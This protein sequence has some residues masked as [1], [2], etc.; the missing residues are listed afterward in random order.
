MK[1]GVADHAHAI[2][3]LILRYAERI[4]AGDLD[5]LAALFDQ[6]VLRTEGFP[7]L[8]RGRDEVRALYAQMVRL[9]DGRPSTQHITTNIRVE[10]SPDEGTAE[11][12]SKYTVFQARPELPLQAIISGRYHDTFSRDDQGWHFTERV[13][14]IDLVGDLSQHLKLAL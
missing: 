8:R 7:D 6:A 12:W 11:A 10:V 1:P 13:I 9:Y 14:S 2:S 4:D 3:G 5:G